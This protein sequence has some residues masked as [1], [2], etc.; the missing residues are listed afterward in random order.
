MSEPIKNPDRDNQVESQEV[1]LESLEDAK[2]WQEYLMWEKFV[3]WCRD[4]ENGPHE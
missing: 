3:L 4:Q 2:E 1:E